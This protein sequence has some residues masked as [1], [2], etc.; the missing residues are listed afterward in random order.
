MSGIAGNVGNTVGGIV[1]ETISP[2]KEK[3]EED[4]MTKFKRKLEKLKLMKEQGII[5]EEEFEK[6]KKKLLENL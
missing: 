1:E 5:N 3:N 4:E 2:T 6:E